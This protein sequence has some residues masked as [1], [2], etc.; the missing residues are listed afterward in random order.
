MTENTSATEVAETKQATPQAP[1]ETKTTAEPNSSLLADASVETTTEQPA[2]ENQRPE[3]WSEEG[4]I[5]L[6]S[7]QRK[8][9]AW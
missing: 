3:W 4:R 8:R 7:R 6:G 9:N 5:V 1:A 2:A